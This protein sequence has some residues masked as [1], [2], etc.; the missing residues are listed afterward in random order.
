MPE[1]MTTK[2]IQNQYQGYLN[3]PLLWEGHKING[4]KQLDLYKSNHKIDFS[5]SLPKNLVL[6]KRVEHFVFSELD[7]QPDIEIISKNIQVHDAT[8][9]LGE[10]DVIL[11]RKSVPLH[12]EIVYKFYLFDPHEAGL[13]LTHWIGP[14]RKD[15]LVHKLEK[16]KK[17]QLPLLYHKLVSPLLKKL[18][19]Q[20]DEVQQFV[21]FKAQLFVPYKGSDVEFRLLN[22]NCVR[23]FYI[24]KNQLAL[25]SACRFYI[26]DKQDWLTEVHPGVPWMPFKPFKKEVEALLEKKRSPMCWINWPDKTMEKMFVV[27]WD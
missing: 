1:T 13:E 9:T 11:R 22:K 17:K 25:F 19:I 27:W 12:L 18:H 4:M 24:H 21:N 16:L 3:T 8:S 7:H 15:S 14:N 10:F 5:G 20:A 2:R 26:P 23:G 6:G